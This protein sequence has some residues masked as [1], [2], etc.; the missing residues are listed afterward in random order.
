MNLSALDC[1]FIGAAIFNM[2]V[3]EVGSGVEFIRKKYRSN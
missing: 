1:Y 2:A 3:Y